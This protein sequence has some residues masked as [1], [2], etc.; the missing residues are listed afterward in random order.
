MKLHKIEAGNFQV[1]GGLHLGLFQNGFGKKDT[2]AMRIIF[3]E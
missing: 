2:P 1:D 3:A